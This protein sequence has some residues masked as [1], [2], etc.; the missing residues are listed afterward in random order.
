[1]KR[2][3]MLVLLVGAVIAGMMLPGTL[4]AEPED[5]VNFGFGGVPK[6]MKH[7]DAEVYIVE[8]EHMLSG[9]KFTVLGRG[10]MV[11]YKFDDGVYV[12]QG[13]PRGVEVGARYYFSGGMKGFLIGGTVGYWMSDWK[14]I[15]YEGTVNESRGNAESKS[16]RVNLDI[17]WRAPIGS[18]VS[19]T[20]TLNI[21]KFVPSTTCEYT[22]PASRVGTPCNE[23]T[24]VKS[25]LY[26]AVMAGIGF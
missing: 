10:S 11:D 23:E 9:S 15:D 5:S 6:L 2:R 4:C 8:Y 16:L 20:P 18:S 24:K 3:S 1:M 22:S 25:Y 12:E 14:F 17:G 7:C 13:Q 19:I 21:G 26:L